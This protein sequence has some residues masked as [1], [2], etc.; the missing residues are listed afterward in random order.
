VV[1]YFAGDD[2]NTIN[3][4]LR[5]LRLFTLMVGKKLQGLATFS[6]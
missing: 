3:T 5:K 4:P 2:E 6:H 1:E